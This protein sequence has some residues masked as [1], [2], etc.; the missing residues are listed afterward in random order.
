MEKDG[1]WLGGYGYRYG[2]GYGYGY[3]MGGHGGV[4]AFGY[5]NARPAYEI[6]IMVASAAIL[7]R[8]G[9]QQPCEDTLAA[10]RDMFDR[11]GHCLVQI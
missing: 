5:Q 6:R 3:P 8:Q 7:A 9:Q 1:L 4:S 10:T 2:Y 11:F